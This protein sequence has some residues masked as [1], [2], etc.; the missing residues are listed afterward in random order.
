MS[1]SKLRQRP[2]S[3][4]RRELDRK[5]ESDFVLDVVHPM[6]ELANLVPEEVV[7]LPPETFTLD[8]L[9]DGRLRVVEPI[10]VLPMFEGGKHVVEAPELNEFGFG[11]NLSEA[12]SDLQAAI[13]ELYFTLEDDQE[14]LGPDLSSVWAELSQ[15]VRKADAIGCS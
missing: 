14:R 1:G 9:R 10:G 5:R 6:A 13:A 4:K 8:S 7:S 2:G 11:D 12:L 3:P 15:K